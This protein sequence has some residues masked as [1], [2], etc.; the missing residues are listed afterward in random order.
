MD[1]RI[2]FVEQWFLRSHKS[3]DDFERF[4]F[5]WLC[6]VCIA[7]YWYEMNCR[8]DRN[9]KSSKD[10]GYFIGH[11]FGAHGN[12]ELIVDVCSCMPEYEKLARRK[13]EN[14]EYILDGVTDDNR[15]LKNLHMHIV[16][17]S[18]MN[19]RSQ[20]EAIG[21]ALKGIRNNLFHG[22]KLYESSEDRALL[23]LA[24]PLL[25][26]IVIKSAQKHMDITL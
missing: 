13:S 25:T 26:A 17:D 2:N 16:F 23:E 6:M 8:S 1:P 14:N 19:S 22:G 10:D 3:D 11:Y 24:T 12:A 15:T 21:K 4:I 20:A 7:K 5:L 9:Y 18:P